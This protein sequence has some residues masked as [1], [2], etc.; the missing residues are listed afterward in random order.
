MARNEV[1]KDADYI[2]LPVNNGTL[3]G[4]PVVVGNLVGVAQTTEGDLVTNEEGYASVALTGAFR[5]SI[6]SE[7]S[8][9]GLPIYIKPGDYSLTAD[10]E[11][12]GN[13]FFGYNLSTKASGAGT[14]IIKIV[15]STPGLTVAPEED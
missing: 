6:S 13:R 5:L 1:Y 14:A 11:V 9:I 3:S 8:T 7:L 12:V 10:D 4:S 15:Q 2:S